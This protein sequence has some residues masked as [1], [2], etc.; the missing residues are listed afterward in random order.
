MPKTK[1]LRLAD[2]DPQRTAEE[3]VQAVYARAYRDARALG[4]ILRAESVPAGVDPKVAKSQAMGKSAA[5][6]AARTCAAWAIAGRGTPEEVAIALREL[7]SVVEGVELGRPVPRELRNLSLTPATE[8]VVVAA[9]ARLALADDRAIEAIE[10]ATLA[11]LDE[12]SIRAAAAAGA[13]PPVGPARPMR[14]AANV[15]RQYL[16][17]RGV[18][19]FAAPPVPAALSA[20]LP[21]ISAP[22][23]LPAIS[24]PAALPALPA[25]TGPASTGSE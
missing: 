12:R 20:P 21:A 13:L 17:E 5:S 15:V 3:V 14:F 6:K 18:P 2:L 16:Y 25:P 9:E 23:A 22:A 24:A 10:V 7:R 1:P 4:L 8:L 19:G 11:S